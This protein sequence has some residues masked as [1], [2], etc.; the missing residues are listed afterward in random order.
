ML[1]GE[2]S[3]TGPAPSGCSVAME[4]DT[5]VGRFS[6]L[7]ALCSPDRL[8]SVTVSPTHNPSPIGDSE[9]CSHLLVFWSP[10]VQVRSLVQL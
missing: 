2:A 10:G 1:P 7:T 3:S 9:A 8:W 6:V 5:L 4:A